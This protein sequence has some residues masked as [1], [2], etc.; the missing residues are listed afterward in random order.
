[1]R[2]KRKVSYFKPERG[3]ENA[4]ACFFMGNGR[5]A[6]DSLPGKK[7]ERLTGGAMLSL[8]R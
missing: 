8:P 6:P 7:R 3:S 1:M 2:D 4:Q 5:E